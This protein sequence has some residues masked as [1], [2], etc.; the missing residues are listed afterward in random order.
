MKS[1]DASICSPPGAHRIRPSPIGTKA[2]SSKV[3]VLPG[4]NTGGGAGCPATR[5]TGMTAPRWSRTLKSATVIGIAL[6]APLSVTVQVQVV[7]R[8]WYGRPSPGTCGPLTVAWTK[9]RANTTFTL[10]PWLVRAG[11]AVVP[12]NSAFERTFDADK[13]VGSEPYV[14]AAAGW[15]PTEEHPLR[16]SAAMASRHAALAVAP[17]RTRHRAGC[18]VP[19]AVMSLNGAHWGRC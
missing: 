14:S 1:Q 16:A 9:E 7:A 15:T 10:S 5:A 2:R 8:V 13:K 11:R 12:V 18:P 19:L 6:V 17:R 4:A 3:K